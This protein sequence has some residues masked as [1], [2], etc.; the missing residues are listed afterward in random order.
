MTPDSVRVR[1][2]TTLEEFGRCVELQ[3]VLWGTPE[4]DLVPKEIFV[5]AWMVGGHLLGA[6]AGAEVIGFTLA[7]PGLRQGQHYL[8]AHMTGV[9]PAY[10]DADIKRRLRLAQRQEALAQG[11]A[12]VEWTFDPLALED[13]DFNLE[14]LGVV[15]RRLERGHY[16]DSTS[17]ALTR[18]PSAH[19]VAEWWL[20]TPRVEATLS[21]QRPQFVPGGP[22][23]SVPVAVGDFRET[24]PAEAE[25]IQVEVEDQ[26]AGWLEKGYAIVGF[27]RSQETG[28]YLLEAPTA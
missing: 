27:E 23:V 7:L 10:E 14:C 8:Y 12:L 22:R 1:P 4:R 28:T 25:R 17:R 13:A 16:G 24:D 18:R 5:V 26:L 9:L 11:F 20:R 3:R 2:C 21:G 15:V 6:F 19:L